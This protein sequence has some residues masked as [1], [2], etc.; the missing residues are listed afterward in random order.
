MSSL[1]AKDIQASYKYG[2]FS[3]EVLKDISLSLESG[4]FV[5]LCGPNGSGKSTL[6]SILSG[7]SNPSLQVQGDRKSVV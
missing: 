7:L 5:C 2:R 1:I 6:L 3:K 4:E